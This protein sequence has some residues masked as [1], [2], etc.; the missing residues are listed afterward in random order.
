MKSGLG[1]KGGGCWG[2]HAG[3]YGT[4]CRIFIAQ[5]T[6]VDVCRARDARTAQWMD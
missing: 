4:N 6:Q 2:G 5:K 3:E 1:A